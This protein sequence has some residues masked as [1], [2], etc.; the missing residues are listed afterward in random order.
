MAIARSVYVISDLHIGGTYPDPN[1]PNPRR[2]RGFR[3][4]TRAQELA[5][6]IQL[7]ADLPDDPPVE[8]VI[9]G[10]FVDFLAEEKGSGQIV[11]GAQ[12]T[13][14][15]IDPRS[16]P[17][18][19][20]FRSGRGEALAAF[21]EL[22]RRDRAVFEALGKLLAAG[23][24]LTIVLGNHDIE[25]T[26]PD[27]RGELVRTLG[28]GQFRFIEDGQALDLGEVLV[29]HG[30]IFDPANVVDHDRLRVF[31][32]LYSRG[33]FE[34]L[35]KVFFPPAGSA[36][37]STVMN[38]IKIDY[39]FIDLLK[40]ESES[41]IAL[42]LA[43]EPSYKSMLDDVAIALARAATTL[44]PRRGAPLVLRNVVDTDT[45]GGG[46]RSNVTDPG[47]TTASLDALIAGVVKDPAVAAELAALGTTGA[48][49]QN[50][51]SGLAGKWSLL[52]LLFGGGKG[53]IEARIPKVQATLG[54]LAADYSFER[55]LENARYLD[56]ARW[57]ATS[58]DD[59]KG[60]KAIVFGHTHHAKAMSIPKTSD[61]SKEASYFNTG[62]WANLMRFPSDFTDPTKSTAEVLDALTAFAKQLK[63][64]DLDTHLVFQPTYVK[65]ELGEKGALIKATLH[66][67]NWKAKQL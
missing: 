28:S 30:N 43:L 57:L 58:G 7:I 14:S 18:W 39:G 62:T 25:L 17:E 13:R 45:S 50:V 35:E 42:L 40:P 5:D 1:A 47:T 48:T 36:L 27:V 52:R 16:E 12:G 60:Y 21:R 2:K 31:R 6:F 38:P 41:L 4:M 56:A 37:V 65:L 26:L 44:V 54:A 19:G 55:G 53:E 24:S 63:D 64:N 32:A 59:Q 61:F 11:V 20:A 49:Q 3:M 23:K 67:Y 15:K 33:W 29:D 9:N 10:D 66:D 46:R 34:N 51:S 22:V 8:L